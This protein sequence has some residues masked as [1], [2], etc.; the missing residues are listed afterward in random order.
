MFYHNIQKW[1]FKRGSADRCLKLTMR[2]T[3][4]RAGT[5][6]AGPRGS[7]PHRLSG[8]L[9]TYGSAEAQ[10]TVS[11]QPREEREHSR[12]FNKTPGRYAGLGPSCT[13]AS[14]L[15]PT[16]PAP[17]GP[18]QPSLSAA[19]TLTPKSS[20]NFTIWWWPAQTALCSGVMPSSL[21]L[22]GSST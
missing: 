20:R 11:G 12:A 3:G 6:A 14:S 15:L 21:G 9:K 10:T 18:H 22:L 2:P 5:A 8:H 17:R 16:T 7:P 13:L 4:R 19:F 1:L